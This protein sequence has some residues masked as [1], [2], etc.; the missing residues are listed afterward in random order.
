MVSFSY[1]IRGLHRELQ[2][3]ASQNYWIITTIVIPKK[4]S[5][6]KLSALQGTPS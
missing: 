3:G 2:P 1:D 5:K 4:D 6:S